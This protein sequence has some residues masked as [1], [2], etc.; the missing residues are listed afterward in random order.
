MTA[1]QRAGQCTILAG[2]PHCCYR[3]DASSTQSGGL[4]ALSLLGCTQWQLLERCLLMACTMPTWWVVCAHSTKQ[5]ASFTAATMPCSALHSRSQRAA[6]LTER[7]SVHAAQSPFARVGRATKLLALSEAAGPYAQGQR[8]LGARPSQLPCYV[9]QT[10][11]ANVCSFTAPQAPPSGTLSS[12]LRSS[13]K[14]TAT[15][16]SNRHTGLQHTGL[17]QEH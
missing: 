6:K 3:T 2:M 10:H 8:Q 16:H 4:V 12:R 9:S 7:P 11:T 5:Q 1:G 13:A 17:K 14:P 15:A